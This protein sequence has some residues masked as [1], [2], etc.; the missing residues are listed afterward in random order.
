M[1]VYI[2]AVA[3]RDA[4]ARQIIAVNERNVERRSGDDVHAN[5]SYV[6]RDAA[7]VETLASIVNVLDEMIN[8]S[9]D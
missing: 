9:V 1:P 8:G 6:I 5:W 4:L 2:D 7:V 3:L